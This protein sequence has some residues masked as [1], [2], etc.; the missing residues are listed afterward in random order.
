MTATRRSRTRRW[1]RKARRAL[2]GGNLAVAAAVVAAGLAVVAVVT[3]ASTPSAQA[4]QQL[5]ATKDL[6]AGRTDRAGR[7]ASVSAR[8]DTADRPI[9][10]AL[11][12]SFAAG[13]GIPDRRGVPA[14][15]FAGPCERSSDNYPHL[16]ARRLHLDLTDVSCTGARAI[17]LI[18][19]S[20]PSGAHVPPQLDAVGPDTD[21]I[22]VSL[23]GNDPEY[24]NR[25]FRSCV[26]I[27]VSDP[28]GAPC[29]SRF[30]A[31]VAQTAAVQL[32]RLRPTLVAA[33]REIQRRAPGARIVVVGYAPYF[34]GEDRCSARI[35]LATGDFAF[36][37]EQYA[38]VITEV[39]LAATDAGVDFVDPA[40]LLGAHDICS[41]DPWVN[42]RAGYGAE[43]YHPF[44]TAHE[45][46]ARL[47]A[48]TL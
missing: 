32:S 48:A 17:D 18:Q 2:T 46:I 9:Y 25:L 8:P 6:E 42:G 29:R 14:G 43:P 10:V 23:G 5:E 24:L 1:R 13:P 40:A 11:G 36:V 31:L 37:A 39:R 34:D 28:L 33:Y 22:T 30:G 12:D 47:V 26:A 20:T 19:E 44:A 4:G 7:S 15:P 3:P 41:A 35:P 38:R 21:L 16:L 45:A 27:A